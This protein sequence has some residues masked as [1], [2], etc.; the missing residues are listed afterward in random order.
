MPSRTLASAL[1]LPTSGDPRVVRG[2]V[3][4]LERRVHVLPHTVR[5]R[6][7]VGGQRLKIGKVRRQG[8][9]NADETPTGLLGRAF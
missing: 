1:S 6:Q 3:H 4:A 2:W 8:G 5:E 7:T 9:G